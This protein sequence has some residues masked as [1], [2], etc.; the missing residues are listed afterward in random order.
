MQSVRG[1]L[2][3]ERIEGVDD[4]KYYRNF[5]ARVEE[6]RHSLLSLLETL[7]SDGKRIAAYGA[8]AKGATLINYVGIGKDIVDFVVDRNVFK[9]GLNMPGKH[10]PIFSTEKLLQ[11]MPDYVLLLSWNFADEIFAQQQAYRDRGGKF[12]V[13]LPKPRIA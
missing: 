12:I 9:Q 13:P 7:K 10:L 11:E 5:A 4:I 8:A 3:S 1:L 6:I 2:E